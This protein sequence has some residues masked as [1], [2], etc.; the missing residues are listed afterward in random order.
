MQ[1]VFRET[2]TRLAFKSSSASVVTHDELLRNGAETL[3]YALCGTSALQRAGQRCPARAGCVI[4]NGDRT[5]AL[6]LEAFDVSDVESV[7]FYPPRSDWSNTLRY[8]GCGVGAN[9]AV[10]WLRAGVR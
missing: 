2:S 3:A 1:Y 5:T 9:V 7:E 10:V 4:V 8:R 6:P